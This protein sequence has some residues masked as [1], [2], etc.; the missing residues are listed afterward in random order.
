MSGNLF[1][2]FSLKLPQNRHPERSA[3]WIY[4][5]TLHLAARSRRTPAVPIF[6][7]LLGAFL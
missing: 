1:E 4:R 3:S 5:V 7:M 2:M 6:P